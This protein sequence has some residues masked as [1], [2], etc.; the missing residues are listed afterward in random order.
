[1]CAKDSDV[2]VRRWRLKE[3][4]EDRRYDSRQEGRWEKKGGPDMQHVLT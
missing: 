2:K 3:G 1:M 4:E